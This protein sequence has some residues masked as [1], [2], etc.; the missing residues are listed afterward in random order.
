MENL[1]SKKMS[2]GITLIALVVTIIVLLLLAGISIQMLTGDN[3]ILQIATEAK[4]ETEK[5]QIIENAQVDVLGQQTENNGNNIT[6]KQLTTILNKYFK[7]VKEADIPDEISSSSD[8]EL[9][10]KDEKYKIM[11]SKVYSGKFHI[12]SDKDGFS[13]DKGVNKPQLSSGMIP[14][15]YNASSEKWIVCSENDNEW[16][17]YIGNDI[18]EFKWANIMLSDGTYKQADAEIGTVVDD[19]Q[20]GSMFVWIPRYAYA[21][22][23]YKVGKNA[24]GTIQNITDVTFLVSNSNKDKDGNSYETDY[25]SDIVTEG[26]STPKIVHPG[27]TF[28][29]SNLTGIWV[30]KFEASMEE[31]NND[32]ASNN[33]VTNKTVKILP[34]KAGWRYIKI[35][36]AFTECFNIK[37]SSKYGINDTADT[38]LTKNIEWGAIVYLAASQYGMT[39]LSNVSKITGSSNYRSNLNQSTTGNI[40]GIFDLNGGAWEFVAAFFDN[41]VSSLSTNGKSI[42][43]PYNQ[44]DN[45][46]EKYWDK[47]TVGNDEKENGSTLWNAGYSQDNNLRI[48]QS[49]DDRYNNA[50]SKKGDAFY[51]VMKYHEYSYYGYSTTGTLTWLLYTLDSSTSSGRGKTIYNFDQAN[52]GFYDRAFMGRGENSN[53]SATTGVFACSGGNGKDVSWDGFRPIIVVE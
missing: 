18:E 32:T 49:V 36:N 38:H 10:T 27:F 30:A 17:N 28:G 46:Y 8:V 13:V 39:P 7:N 12:T 23:E 1:K 2:A 9:T 51:E 14:I 35:G 21:I 5:S 37:S 6:K 40:T 22:K 45:N 42:Y 19:D 53:T 26:D 16:Y 52:I 25:N 41:G 44:L 47:Y 20:L 11:L 43:F 31:N 29:N 4:I 15:K 34:G 33:D 48:R 3:G 24:E 50:K